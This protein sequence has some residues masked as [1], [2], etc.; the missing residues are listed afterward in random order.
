MESIHT[1]RIL[2]EN[3]W[4]WWWCYKGKKINVTTTQWTVYQAKGLYNTRIIILLTDTYKWY[5][6]TQ[7][8]DD[9]HDVFCVWSDR[10]LIKIWK[11]WYTFCVHTRSLIIYAT[12]K[13][14]PTI[15]FFLSEE[16]RF[17]CIATWFTYVDGKEEYILMLVVVGEERRKQ[18]QTRRRKKAER[19]KT[20]IIQNILMYLIWGSK[21]KYLWSITGF[22]CGMRGL[23]VDLVGF[24][25]CVMMMQYQDH[26]NSTKST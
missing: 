15:F 10:Y 26:P 24:N 17:F 9:W 19:D 3:K 13:K 2:Y 16:I 12:R 23:I 8:R 5:K 6:Y 21:K 22:F 14:L 18:R 7:R 25:V 11:M 20:T 4:W 1:T